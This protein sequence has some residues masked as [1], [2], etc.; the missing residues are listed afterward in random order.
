[1][2]KGN[3]L[4]ESTT[5]RV[6]VSVQS[7]ELLEQLGKRGIYGR[8]VAEVAGRFIDEALQRYVEQPKLSISDVPKKKKGRA[9]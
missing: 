4:A 2:A 6:T 5:F 1:M 8:N 7:E 9:K 3:N